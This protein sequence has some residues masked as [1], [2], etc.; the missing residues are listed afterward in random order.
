MPEFGH[1]FVS[2]L[3]VLRD[4]EFLDD[5]AAA[6]EEATEAAKRTGKP[7]VLT[8]AFTLKPAQQGRNVLVNEQIKVKAATPATADTLLF[9]S[10]DNRLTRRDPRQPTLPGM[11]A[12]AKN[13]PP[14]ESGQEIE[15]TV[16]ADG[17]VQEV[18]A[19]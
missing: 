19:Q 6:L 1:P 13:E 11:T 17:V 3:E 8:L 2:F 7:A 12:V 4:Q 16:D 9:V 15:Y 14:A 5:A 10:D 18:K